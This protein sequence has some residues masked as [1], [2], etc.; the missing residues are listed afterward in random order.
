MYQYKYVFAQ[1]IAFLPINH[2]LSS[3]GHKKRDQP[4]RTGP[5]HYIRVMIT[6]QQQP[7]R[8]LD[9]TEYQLLTELV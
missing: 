6:P 4:K 1:L 8:R 3:C 7:V 2:Q 5:F 9:D